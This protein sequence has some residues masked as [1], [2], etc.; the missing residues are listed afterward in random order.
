MSSQWL[1]SIGSN[2][3]KLAGVGQGDIVLSSALIFS[4]TCNPITYEKAIPVFI[5]SEKDTWN[6]DP[7]ALEGGP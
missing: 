6:I 1:N 4:A 3:F 5:D 7:N 2:N